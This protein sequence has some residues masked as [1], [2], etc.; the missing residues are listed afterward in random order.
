MK[1]F[2]GTADSHGT[3]HKRKFAETSRKK[4]K[5]NGES[6]TQNLPTNLDSSVIQSLPKLKYPKNSVLMKKD[7]INSNDSHKNIL[8]NVV[9]GIC[10]V[11]E[12][13]LTN[14]FST[15]ISSGSSSSSLQPSETKMAAI[16]DSLLSILQQL[17][18]AIEDSCDDNVTFMPELNAEE[19]RN[20]R[21]LIAT[22]NALRE[23][24]SAL[25]EFEEIGSDKSAGN[26]TS[27]SDAI[28]HTSLN[29]IYDSLVASESNCSSNSN[30]DSSSANHGSENA[31][32]SS[33]LALEKEVK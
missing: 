18:P 11:E 27:S 23:Q 13:N 19:R 8:C 17:P 10:S 21:E 33:L 6:S 32:P 15:V 2:S 7:S 22:R 3:K 9:D 16:R 1:F 29:T 14:F 24:Y 4:P 28:A 5:L 30:S 31:I 25:L 20:R 12:K 26:A